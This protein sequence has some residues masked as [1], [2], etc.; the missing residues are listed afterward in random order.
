MSARR[1]LLDPERSSLR[2]AFTG[3]AQEPVQG[4]FGTWSATL[5]LDPEELARTEV[6][7]RVAAASIDTGDARRDDLLRGPLFLGTAG[8]RVFGFSGRQAVHSRD[9]RWRLLGDLTINDSTVPLLVDVTWG[10]VV[11]DPSGAG[12]C[13]TC[14]ARCSFDP[15]RFGLGPAVGSAGS[16]VPGSVEIAGEFVFII[17][18][19][20]G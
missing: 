19:G 13:V 1:W 4:E 15:G 10:G 12:A 11:A 8:H 18:E 9:A 3:A 6:E 16:A 17:S 20:R 2:F 14:S 7:V 5:M